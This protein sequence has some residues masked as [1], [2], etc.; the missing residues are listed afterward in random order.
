M[1]TF[2]TILHYDYAYICL[3]SARSK[4]D[5]IQY[6]YMVYRLMHISFVIMSYGIFQ[7][8]FTKLTPKSYWKIG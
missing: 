3:K 5:G 2:I 7:Q 4:P 6:I 8:Q 1:P